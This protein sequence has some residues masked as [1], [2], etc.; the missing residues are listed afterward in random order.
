[1]GKYNDGMLTYQELL[2][3]LATFTEITQAIQAGKM[4]NLILLQKAWIALTTIEK[5]A[6]KSNKE[7]ASSSSSTSTSDEQELISIFGNL[8]RYLLA[9]NPMFAQL[10]L[11][12]QRKDFVIEGVVD[13]LIK[14]KILKKVEKISD[15]P[16]SALEMTVK[17]YSSLIQEKFNSLSLDYDKM[18]KGK[19]LI[20]QE[21]AV[22]RINRRIKQ[23]ILSANLHVVFHALALVKD[24][25]KINKSINQWRADFEGLAAAIKSQINIAQHRDEQLTD[26]TMTSSSRLEAS[27]SGSSTSGRN[28]AGNVFGLNEAPLPV[29]KSSTELSKVPVETD[30]QLR[31]GSMPNL[32][33][34]KNKKPS[35][36]RRPAFNGSSSGFSLSSS[37]QEIASSSSSSSI[38]SEVGTPSVPAPAAKKTKFSDPVVIIEPVKTPSRRLSGAPQ[39]SSSL[40]A[41][42]RSADEGASAGKT[43]GYEA[44]NE[45]G[46][47]GGMRFFDK[48]AST[49]HSSKHRS[50]PA[51]PK[52]G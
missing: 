4:K 21:E 36:Q 42:K 9:P 5:K 20:E 34:T 25:N 19:N 29:S 33:P 11:P 44:E 18:I 51:K 8:D 16:T 15:M 37:F 24:I 48:P 22:N 12:G 47:V 27:S 40:A 52:R 2:K 32:S 13:G 30:V 39:P 43:S 50:V 38:D 49:K 35:L 46:T 6:E 7:T 26:N 41:K 17:Q 45:G 1:M 3:L 31:T 28:R 23:E 10:V 14:D